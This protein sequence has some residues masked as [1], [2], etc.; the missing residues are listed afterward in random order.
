MAADNNTARKKRVAFLFRYGI[1]DH[2]ELF[3]SMSEIIEMLGRDYEVL[4]VAPNGHK[5]PDEYRYPG[6]Q[7]FRVPFK[8]NRAS[9][10]D[11][12]LKTI[13]W[14]LYLPF[15]SLYLRFWRADLI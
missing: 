9:S 10:S 7:Y 8:V 4:Y 12:L 15:L 1:K 13:L 6:V 14:Y 3:G 11:K 2:V 5:I